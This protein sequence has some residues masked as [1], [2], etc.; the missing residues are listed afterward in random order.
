MLL[1]FR[2]IAPI[3]LKLQVVMGTLQIA[4]IAQI[5][6][7]SLTPHQPLTARMVMTGIVLTCALVAI[8][9]I[10]SIRYI[11]RPYEHLTRQV[12]R[13]AAG[14][15]H[16]DIPY[17]DYSDCVGRIAKSLAVFRQSTIEKHAAEHRAREQTE[18]S[19]LASERARQQ[20]EEIR[21]GQDH[22]IT[23]LGDALS[24]LSRGDLMYRVEQPFARDYEKIREDFNTTVEKLQEVILRVASSASTISSGSSQIASATD[25]LAKRTE[26]QVASLEET[27]TSVTRLTDIVQKTAEA[28]THANAVAIRTNERSR[29]TGENLTLTT[30]AMRA[31]EKSSAEI[32]QILGVIDEIAFQT[33]LLA[34]NAGV[35]AARAGDAGR[36]FSV[37]ASEVRA[38]AQRSGDAAR[39]IKTL[40]ASSSEQ[41]SI[42]VNLVNQTREI[43]GIAI[44]SVDEITTLISQI[45]TSAHIQASSL[46]QINAAI[47]QIDGA[48]QQNAAMVE[49]TTA[50]GHHLSRETRELVRLVGRFRVSH[51]A[52][53][54]DVLERRRSTSAKAPVVMDKSALSERA[55]H[56]EENWDAF[57]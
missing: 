28:A 23:T 50:A 21:R 31:I 11:A 48:T 3:R 52:I 17:T 33:N 25:D 56:T 15:I 42:G 1:W 53:S 22:L 39:K 10:L 24:R 35:E 41:I 57:T 27:A 36:G 43:G 18:Q 7:I 29:Q 46:T 44:A 40:I 6:L 55:L 12:E 13:L 47:N 51:A 2:E 9:T 16:T 34:L 19:R 32:A 20:D 4:L 5:A 49:E 54:R 38:L 8:L 45:T 30:E 37:V 26:Q 14:D